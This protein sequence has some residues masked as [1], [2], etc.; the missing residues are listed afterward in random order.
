LPILETVV[1]SISHIDE[2]TY[3]LTVRA[4]LRGIVNHESAIENLSW[5]PSFT[6]NNCVVKQNRARSIL[7]STPGNVIVEGNYFSSMMAGIRICGD[8]NYWYESGPVS[9]VLIRNNTFEELGI[10]GHNPQAILQIDPVIKK[11]YRKDGYYH[12]NI[13]FEDNLIKTFDPHI[14]YSLSVDGLTIRNNKIIQTKSY[15][16]IFS[17]LCQFDIQNCK[18]VKILNNEYVGED[19]ALISLKEVSSL[20]IKG[21][22]GFSKNTV[23][24][25][26]KYFYE[27]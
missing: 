6:M 21:Q 18:N 1:D 17:D 15:S 8:A 16:K 9:N 13:V 20:S 14:I 27:N 5:M 19:E 4:N 12:K 25:P 2:S 26:N 23:E 22:K 7:I 3:L 24:N 10:G 11:G